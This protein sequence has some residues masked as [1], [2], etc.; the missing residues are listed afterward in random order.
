MRKFFVLSL[1]GLVSLSGG[2]ADKHACETLDLV[3]GKGLVYTPVPCSSLERPIPCTKDWTDEK[4]SFH[5]DVVPC[6]PGTKQK[7]YE[8]AAREE[9][10]VKRAKCG[11]DYKSARIG[12]LASRF[13]ECTDGLIY[14][15]ET[16]TSKGVTE[17]YRT[18]FYYVYVKDG[19]IVGLTRR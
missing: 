14:V 10:Q 15:T 16:L 1:L 19:R 11:K 13:S 5:S 4:G 8:Q 17:T 18:T 7:T 3:P 12:M 2:A 9:E 6:P